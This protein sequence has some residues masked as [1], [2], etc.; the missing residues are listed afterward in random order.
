MPYKPAISSMSLGRAWLHSLPSKLDQAAAHGYAGIELFDEDLEYHAASLPGGAT[1]S[2]RLSAA[3]EIRQ[4]CDARNLEIIALQPFM[5]YEGV[6]DPAEH[7]ELIEKFKLWLK[8]A[9]ILGTYLI[10]IPSNFR[11]EGVTGEI[12]VLVSDLREVADLAARESPVVRVAYESLC[13]GTFVDTWE[14]S[15]G[16]VQRVD[17]ENLG[18]CLDTFNICG[19]VYAD[20]TSED[21]KNKDADLAMEQSMQ[22]LRKDVDPKKVFFCQLIDAERLER[23][24]DENHPYHISAQPPR[25]SWSRNAR[26]FPFE[27]TA[28]LPVIEALKAITGEEGLGYKGWVSYELFSRTMADPS[29]ECPMIHAQRGIESWRKLERV[30]RWDECGKD[31]EERSTKRDSGKII[32]LDVTV[33][34][35]EARI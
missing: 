2:N 3:H 22:R 16:L 6:L 21:G 18:L 23:P 30:M 10:Q 35:F 14:Q 29:P 24:L 34:G 32:D 33:G 28:Y 31:M 27:S 15:W 26:C 5:H 20:P 4:M 8:L 17:R 25:M 7:A 11:T 19:R 13:W 12:D 1:D 9:K